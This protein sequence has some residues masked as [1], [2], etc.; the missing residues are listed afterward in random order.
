M[1]EDT[2]PVALAGCSEQE[3]EVEEEEDFDSAGKRFT[4]VS[5]LSRESA[6]MKHDT[7]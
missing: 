3:D 5:L 4:F 2:D 7:I 1:A 6:K